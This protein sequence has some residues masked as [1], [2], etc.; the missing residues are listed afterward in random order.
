[1]H[2]GEARPGATRQWLLHPRRSVPQ[3]PRL[4][5][6]RSAAIRSLEGQALGLAARKADLTQ[7]TVQIVRPLRPGVLNL[8]R[9]LENARGS[10][11]QLEAG[12][13]VALV[14]LAGQAPS[15]P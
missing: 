3:P 13:E 10:A 11:G 9:K 15:P 1:M 6:Q 4:D 5:E 2:K 12:K 7:H 14:V 8:M